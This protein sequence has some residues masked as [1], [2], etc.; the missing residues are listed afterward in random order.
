MI[1]VAGVLT[2]LTGYLNS[3]ILMNLNRTSDQRSAKHEENTKCD[4]IWEEE[5]IITGA[6]YTLAN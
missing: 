6:K 3:A 4:K 5:S 1:A 2:D